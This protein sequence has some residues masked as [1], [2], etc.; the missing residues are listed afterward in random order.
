M[1]AMAQGGLD[2]DRAVQLLERRVALTP[3]NRAAH[4]ALGQ[5]YVDQGR[6]ET[7]YA[8]L[9][10]ALLL[11]PLD[12]GTLTA[13]GQLHLAAGRTAPAVAALE[14]ALALETGNSQALHALGT[15]LV[16]AGRTAEGQR[17]LE[18]S[19][20]RQAQDVED[21]RSRRTA[22]MLAV[23]AE[24]HV[25]RGEHDAA[26]DLF[27]QAITIRRD[28][29]GTLQVSGALIEAGRLEEAAAVLQAAIRLNPRPET[30][31]RLAEVYAALGLAEES[32]RERQTYTEQR[33]EEL[34]R[35]G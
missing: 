22:A 2:Y 28:S 15:A 14:R 10:T 21:Q 23:Q 9:V 6:E 30:H 35:G 17:R 5:A 20:R 3:N 11:D 1:A 26:I 4:Q 25:S 27:K 33:L 18:E 29:V 8:E 31:R 24:I 34:R 32:A 19:V 12:A 7:A 13:L 16:R